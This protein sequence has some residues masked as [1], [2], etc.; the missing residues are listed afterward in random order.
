MTLQKSRWMLGPE[1]RSSKL[2]PSPWGS[3]PKMICHPAWPGVPWEP[4]AFLWQVEKEMTL[5]KSRWMLGP[6]GRSS[7]LQPSPEGLGTN[8]E[9]DLSAVGAVLN[10][11]APTCV[12]I[13]LC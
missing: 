7:K 8:P 5:Q 10:L 1:G 4:P 6:E 3:I 11:P 9:D 12:I 13:H 2:Q